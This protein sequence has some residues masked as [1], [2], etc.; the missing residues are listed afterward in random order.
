MPTPKSAKKT[1]PLTPIRVRKVIESDKAIQEILGAVEAIT[2]TVNELVTS[3]NGMAEDMAVV[4][5]RTQALEATTETLAKAGLKWGTI[6]E[7][8]NKMARQVEGMANANS[9][10]LA[11]LTKIAEANARVLEE[12]RKRVG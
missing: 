8:N 3:Y 1:A 2:A 9:K 7:D 6:A 5:S 12:L 10:A 11:E 4:L